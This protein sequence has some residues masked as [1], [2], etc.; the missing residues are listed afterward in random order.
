[1]PRH[2]FSVVY[3][4]TAKNLVQKSGII[5]SLLDV[6][7]C[8]EYFYSTTR[9]NTQRYYTPRHLIRYICVLPRNI[10]RI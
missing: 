9:K 3:N 2:L 5:N 8:S 6:L 10:K 4:L 1:M 7:V